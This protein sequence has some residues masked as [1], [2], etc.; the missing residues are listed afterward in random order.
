VQSAWKP[1]PHPSRP[2]VPDAA[3]TPPV[4]SLFPGEGLNTTRA[5][6]KGLSP[7]ANRGAYP[8]YNATG[9]L[10]GLFPAFVPTWAMSLFLTSGIDG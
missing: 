5:I 10:A 2:F 4:A 7:A 3:I 6:A 8:D 9:M 1:V